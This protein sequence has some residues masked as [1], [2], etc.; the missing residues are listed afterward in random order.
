MQKNADEEK[1]DLTIFR[2]TEIMH[3]FRDITHENKT[4]L[5]C[6]ITIMK[7]RINGAYIYE[8]NKL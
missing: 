6:I 4:T 5:K 1:K 3:V 8:G 7:N 2:N